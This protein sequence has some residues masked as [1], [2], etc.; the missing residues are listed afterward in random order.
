VRIG[1][2]CSTPMVPL[3]R[4][5]GPKRAMQMLLTGDLIDAATAVEWGL[6]N[7]AV[8]AEALHATV[9]DLAARIATASPMVVALGKR[10]FYEQIDRGLS[11]AYALTG[12]VMACNLL[13]P[14]AAEGIDAF[15]AKRQANWRS[16]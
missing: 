15:V 6:I 7:E 3:S 13:D 4:A 2:F 14:D 11:D 16:T 10:A 5:I 12:D 9:T 8:E 1:L